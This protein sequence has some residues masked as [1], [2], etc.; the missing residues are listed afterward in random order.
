MLDLQKTEINIPPIK[1][2]CFNNDIIDNLKQHEQEFSNQE[3]FN[4]E[5]CSESGDI[6]NKEEIIS[7]N[8]NDEENNNIL[9][10]IEKNKLNEQ[11]IVLFSSF[12]YHDIIT[13]CN[14][15]FRCA[16]LA[17]TGTQKHYSTFR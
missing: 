15:F 10:N 11:Q 6:D 14:S 7:N 4:V 16:S 12:Y 8:T 1:T 13:D 3:Q 9:D 5:Q 17:F 2:E